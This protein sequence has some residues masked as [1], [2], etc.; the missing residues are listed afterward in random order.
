MRGEDWSARHPEPGRVNDGVDSEGLPVGHAD[1]R[2]QTGINPVPK[3]AV[4]PWP[5]LSDQRYMAHEQFLSH[6]K[7]LA[8]QA[9]LAHQQ[10]IAQHVEL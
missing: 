6:Q 5:S 9:F 2:Y 8:Q 3:R 7:F 1:D 4:S 10:F